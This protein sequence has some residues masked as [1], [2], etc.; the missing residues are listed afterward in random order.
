MATRLTFRSCD[1][2]TRPRSGPTSSR[3]RRCAPGRT[4]SGTTQGAAPCPRNICS[5]TGELCWTLTPPEMTVLVGGLRCSEPTTEVPGGGIDS[6]PGS[7]TNDFFV[8]LLDPG[9]EPGRHGT[10]PRR[11]TRASDAR[12][13]ELR[14]IGEPR[15]PHLRRA[16]SY[17]RSEVY[18]SD[19]AGGKF[20]RLRRGLRRSRGTRPVRI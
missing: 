2:P 9:T 20:V 14:W 1:V 7:L 12:T 3:S 5:W 13:G 18:A 4:A 15:R 16:P 19:D 6:A 10:P 11:S 17:G 8:N